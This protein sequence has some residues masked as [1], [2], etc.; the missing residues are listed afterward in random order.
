MEEFASSPRIS[1][2]W[3]LI[4]RGVV[5]IGFG[6]YLLGLALTGRPAYWLAGVASV[7]LSMRVLC[8]SCRCESAHLMIHNVFRT[9]RVPWGDIDGFLLNKRS[10]YLGGGFGLGLARIV[11]SRKN[12]RPIRI[13]PT[14]SIF[15]RKGTWFDLVSGVPVKSEKALEVLNRF[16]AAER[17]RE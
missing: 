1:R 14:Q 7:V 12:G 10:L 16:L 17:S 8:V 2:F 15:D 3:S 5:G 4:Y 6:S 13:S 9:V 11:V